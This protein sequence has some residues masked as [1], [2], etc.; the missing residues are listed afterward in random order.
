MPTNANNS[1]P[2]PRVRRFHTPAAAAW[3]SSPSPDSDKLLLP[4]DGQASVAKPPLYTLRFDGPTPPGVMLDFGVELHGG[5]QITVGMLPSHAPA[6]LRVRFGESY[7]E[8][9]SEPNQDHSVHDQYV[10]APW[11]GS[12]EI[13]N[14]GFRF[15]RID[16]VDAGSVLLLQGV[17]AVS[18]MRPIEQIGSFECSDD[19][20]NQIWQTGARTVH[21]CMQDYLWDGIKRDRLVWVGDL[22]PETSVISAVFGEQDIVPASLDFVRDEFPLPAWMNGISSYS[23]WWIIIHRDWFL[24]YGRID[25]LRQQRTYLLELLKLLRNHIDE[26]GRETLTGMRFL[27]WPTADNPVAVHA[28]LQAMMVLGM[29]AGTELCEALGHTNDAAACRSAIAKL[30]KHVP[31]APGIKQPNSLLVLAGLIDPIKANTDELARNPLSGISTFYGYYLLQARAKAG[32]IA[33]CL[34]LIHTYWG[35][36]LDR[37]ATTF[38]EDFDLA[39]LDNAGRIDSPTPHGQKDLHADFGGYC[40]VGLRHSLCHGWAAGPTAWLSEHVLG[41]QRVGIGFSAVRVKPQL[42]DLQWATGTYP[43]PLGP[44][45]VSAEKQSDGSTTT[46]IEAPNEIEV[47]RD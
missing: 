15:V 12:L 14:T 20:L 35:A 39:W 30:Q 4:C 40:Y 31:V 21:L 33:G 26:D 47:Q 22:H 36:M 45:R 32:D 38:W 28:G 42:G 41:I 7:T 43:T 37:G 2:D 24:N 10:F 6:R 19:R 29:Q 8:A 17:R 16:L 9:M 18:L 5:V 25:Y 46:Q 11:C 1:R 13:G 44:V 27:D 23:L 3:Q 34:D